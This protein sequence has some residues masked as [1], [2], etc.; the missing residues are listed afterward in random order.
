M[1]AGKSEIKNLGRLKK[2]SDFLCV[3]KSGR[4]WISKGIIVEIADNDQSG[5]RYGLTVSKKVSKLAV[6]RNRIKRRL[7]AVACDVLPAYN[8][9]H[10]DIVLIGRAASEERS[11]EDLRNDLRWCLGKMGI[12]ADD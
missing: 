4:K 6:T 2:R 5:L 8:G 7:R 11:Y 3:Q 10:L 9:I 1:F 12:K